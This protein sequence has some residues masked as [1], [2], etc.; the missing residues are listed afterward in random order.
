MGKDEWGVFF[1]A[2]GGEGRERK[3]K[4]GKGKG[5]FWH[6]AAQKQLMLELVSRGIR[7]FANH[8]TDRTAS[9]LAKLYRLFF[10]YKLI[11]SEPFGLVLAAA[12]ITRWRYTMH[13]IQSVQNCS[14]MP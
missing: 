9:F 5:V 3:G 2:G 1:W 8:T 12:V 14:F 10:G 4:E 7:S 13:C 11:A 6:S